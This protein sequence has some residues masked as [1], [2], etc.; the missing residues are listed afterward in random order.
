M[1]GPTEGNMVEDRYRLV[2]RIGSGGMAEVWLAEDT[3]LN[4]KVA[5]KIL[6]SRFAQDEEFVERFRREASA[7][8]GLQHPNV[9]SIFDRG[10]FDDTYFIAMENVE[11]PSLKDLVKGGIG[12]QEAIDYTRQVLAAARFAHRKGIVHRDLKPQNVL[13]DSEGRARVADF[14]IARAGPSEITQTGSVMGTAQY[15]SPEQ[16]QGKEV[17]PQSDVYSVGVI[18]YEALT[19]QV[20]FEGDSAVAVALK[21]V[22]EQP[23]RPSALNPEVPPAL[24]AVVMRALAKDPEQRFSNA[25]AFLKGLDAAERHPNSPRPEDTAAIPAVGVGGE[26]DGR[27]DEEVISEEW[28]RADRR[29]RKR[30]IVLALLLAAIAAVVAFAL[31]R[32]D[33]I[34]VPTVIGQDVGTATQVLEARGFD[35]D[36]RLVPNAAARDT[37]LEQDPR[38]E[39]TADEGSPV[40]LTVSSGPGTVKVPDVSGLSEADA[41]K[42]LRDAGLVVQ[43]EFVFSEG[44]PKGRVVGTEPA[45]ATEVAGGSPVTLQI[46]KGS[47][48]VEVPSLVGQT[49][50][51][52]VAALEAAGLTASVVQRDDDAPA[53]QVVQQTPPPGQ[54]VARGT[55]VTVFAS[56]GAISVPSVIG[57]TRRA[58]V[59][60]LKGAGFGVTVRQDTAATQQQKGRVTNQFPSGGSR[61]QRGDTVTLF[62]GAAQPQPQPQPEPVP[63]P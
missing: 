53:G 21:Q 44:V 34:E 15:L 33:R 54:L 8:A 6:H 63:T 39:Q 22:S 40:T 58:A 7:A 51:Q 10:Q 11:G 62:V 35:V 20:P 52:A 1:A 19:G 31:T 18:L 23:R 13:I 32:P 24:D 25:D 38:A 41:T 50:E 60:T 48:R 56:S 26:T 61:A 16:A 55:A 27:P 49:T 17:T 14:G 2:S 29:G 28:R 57:S 30:W 3:E 43:P 47:N 12:V 9:I 4:R 37:V 46:S 42:T 45:A 36:T 5:L 59:S